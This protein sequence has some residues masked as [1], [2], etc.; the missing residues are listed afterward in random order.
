MSKMGVGPKLVVQRQRDR[1]MLSIREI[2]NEPDLGAAPAIEEIHHYVW[3]GHP[4]RSGGLWLCRFIDGTFPPG[5]VSKHGFL[6]KDWKGAAEDIFVTQGGMPALVD[7]A[8]DIVSRTKTGK[9][10]AATVIVD[11][12]IWTPSQ[13]WHVY[14]G[15]QHFHVHVDVSGGSACRP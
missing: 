7:V 12:D 2:T 5:S 13:G 11:K 6:T 8:E 14:S 10:K 1:D 4:V 3:E 9:L 15:N